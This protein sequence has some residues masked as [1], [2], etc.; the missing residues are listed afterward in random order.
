MNIITSFKEYLR[1]SEAGT[2]QPGVDPAA[3][4]AIVNNVKTLASNPNTKDLDAGDLV[5]KAAT[6]AVVSGQVSPGAAI[7]ALNPKPQQKMMRK[8]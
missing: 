7:K 8:K 1:L 5:N 2:I 3:N 4:N 6:K